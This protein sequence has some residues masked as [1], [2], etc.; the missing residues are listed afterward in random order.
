MAHDDPATLLDRVRRATATLE[1]INA[2]WGQLDE[3]PDDVRARLHRA[4]AALS[5]RDPVARRRRTKAQERERKAARINKD[6]RVLAGTG[7]RREHR[8]PVINTPNQ[9]RPGRFEPHDIAPGREGV[10]PP[11]LEIEA[12]ACYI[13]KRA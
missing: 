2:D 13:C 7:I 1:S 4:I 9:L 12:R 8:R 6:E 3:L 11:D 10:S 5:L